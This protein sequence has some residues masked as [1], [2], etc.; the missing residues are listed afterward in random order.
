MHI[1]LLESIPCKS[2]PV[3]N[4][5]EMELYNLCEEYFYLKQDAENRHPVLGQVRLVDAVK[6]DTPNSYISGIQYTAL[7][8]DILVTDLIANPMFVFEA[9]G[10]QHK[11]DPQLSRDRLKDSISEKAGIDVFR[12]E[13]DG[14]HPP[15]EVV[16]AEAAIA[17]FDRDLEYP[18]ANGHICY[19][20]SNFPNIQR[21]LTIED[22]ELILIR[23]GIKFP[24]G[25]KFVTDYELR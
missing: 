9:D 1:D 15:L 5:Y 6:V 18:T 11:V 17:D 21:F 10:P 16:R 25:W 2:K 4:K 23:S 20:E 19:S 7:S 24:P 8:F 13:V 22:I 14:I 12:V 3:L